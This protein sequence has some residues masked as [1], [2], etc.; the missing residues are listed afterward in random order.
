MAPDDGWDCDEWVFVASHHRLEPTARKV[1][2]FFS[3]KEYTI[4]SNGTWVWKPDADIVLAT[5]N[6]ASCIPSRKNISKPFGAANYCKKDLKSRPDG[7]P[8]EVLEKIEKSR[9]N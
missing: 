2:G 9:A 8:A 3:G 4:H 1:K 5:Q 6:L 7:P